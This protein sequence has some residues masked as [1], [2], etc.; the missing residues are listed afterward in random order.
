MSILRTPEAR[1][2]NLKDFNFEPNYLELSYKSETMRMH[3]LDE[4]KDSD[5]VVLL[6]HGEPTWCYLYRHIIPLLTKAGKRVI[7]PDLIGFGKS[8]KLTKREDYT[9]ANHI[10]WTTQLFTH[11]ALNNVIFFAQ[12]WGGLIGLRIL[13][14][15]PEKFS[16]LVVSNSGLPIGTGSTEGFKQWLDYSQTVEDFNAG[17]IVYQ[18]SLKALDSDEIDAY[19]APFPDESYKVAARVFP[20]IVPMNKDQAQVK[21][22]IEAWEVLKDFQKPTISIFGE[23]DMSFRDQDKYIIEKIAGAKGMNHQRINAGHFSQENQPELIADTILSI[24]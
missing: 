19:N 22:N 5:D 24:N 10:D 20:T 7:A 12:D 9:Y 15:H 21:E 3:Y 2:E 1:F 17:K 11:L 23:H 4:N 13:T 8:D 14:A 18:G 6:L 16:G